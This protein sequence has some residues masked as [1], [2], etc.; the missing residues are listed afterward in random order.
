MRHAFKAVFALAVVAVLAAAAAAQGPAWLVQAQGSVL[1]SGPTG[2]Q[3]AQVPMEVPPGS[4]IRTGSG[5]SALLMLADGSKVQVRTDSEFVLAQ[6][7]DSETVLSL[8]KG[9]FGGW[10]QH[11]GGRRLSIRTPGAVASV[12]GTV[13]GTSTD[14]QNSQFELYAGEL[15]VGDAF[16]KM[17]LLSPGQIAFLDVN[18]G[19]LRTSSMPPG[20]GVPSEPVGALPK[21]KTKAEPRAGDDGKQKKADKEIPSETSEPGP[22]GNF[23]PP[24]PPS[25][26]TTVVSPSAP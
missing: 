8:L 26:Q 14:G 9:A 23:Q 4:T 17:T 2:P 10:F 20:F 24:A 21:M 6:A 5:G 16:G 3:Q 13:T 22:T 25:Q 11:Q 19:L 12:R 7:D 18:R 15:A 1:V